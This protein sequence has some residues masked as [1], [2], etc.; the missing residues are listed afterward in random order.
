MSWPA[1][2]E[3]LAGRRLAS[4][5]CQEAVPCSR[6]HGRGGSVHILPDRHQPVNQILKKAIAVW[7]HRDVTACTHR[8]SS[9]ARSPGSGCSLKPRKVHSGQTQRQRQAQG[10]KAQGSGSSLRAIL[11]PLPDWQADGRARVRTRGMANS[12]REKEELTLF[13]V[14]AGAFPPG[15]I[16]EDRINYGEGAMV[17]SLRHVER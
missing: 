10:Q 11:P 15:H 14:P 5:S 4:H 9:N 3:T 7:V 16:T 2:G 1:S 13:V 12:R 6:E 8:R 17:L